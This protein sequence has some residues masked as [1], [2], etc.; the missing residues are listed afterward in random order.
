[1]SSQEQ[2]SFADLWSDGEEAIVIGSDSIPTDA[3]EALAEALSGVMLA[4]RGD[5]VWTYAQDIAN[6]RLAAA[7]PGA[8]T[9]GSKR[10]RGQDGA[11]LGP[12]DHNEVFRNRPTM[13]PMV[14][15]DVRASP[16][17]TTPSSLP[18]GV[19]DMT[20]W[21]ST[22]IRFGKLA[23]KSVTYLEFARDTSEGAVGYRKW[24]MARRHSGGPELRDLA[25]F[26]F[27]LEDCGE[28]PQAPK[29]AM[30]PGSSKPR[31]T[32]KDFEPGSQSSTAAPR[33]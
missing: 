28:L 13:G 27:A 9:D 24:L 22:I 21:G 16:A 2:P 8:M 10:L 23:Q 31:V 25:E 4:G 11:D 17:P 7:Q 3:E 12:L 26:L 1:M 33:R 19:K 18:D 6:R 29:T 15:N 20:V 32:K 30:I 14:K 5:L